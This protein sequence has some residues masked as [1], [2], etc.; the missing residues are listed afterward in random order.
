[1]AWRARG[2]LARALTPLAVLFGALAAARRAAYALGWRV[3]QT[4]AVPVIVVGNL[5]VGGA[6]KTPTVIAVVAALRR[7]GHVPGI[8]S[9][10]YGRRDQAVMAVR[11]DANPADCGD[12]P[13]LLARRT[14]SPVVVGADRV[15][16][17][18]ELLRRHPDV[19]V[20]VS[21]DGLQHLALARQVQVLVFDERG[22]GNGW[23]L[24]AGPLREPLP[25]TLPPRSLVVY[26]ATR[27]TTALPGTVAQRTLDGVVLL[28]DW[29]AGLAPSP[30][31]LQA[32]R[33][34][35]VLAVAGVAQPQRFFDML[36]RHG[37]QI[38]PIPL[39]D[40][41]D[42]V[43][44]PWPAGAADV[45]VT[46]KDAVKLDA[47]RTGAT[48]VWVAPLDFTLGAAFEAALLD[49]L[50]LPGSRHGNTTA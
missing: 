34:R 29:W 13:L 43:T 26:N 4:L 37:L 3:P 15:A 17:V 45:V 46:E 12:E 6:G 42:Y 25:A 33:D 2:A 19:D 20:I 22:A 5:V 9:R 7:R 14:G 1:M 40:H 18:R 32:L 21:D 44:L 47:L 8:V 10:G 11:P 30:A 24:P 28:R 41:Y 36:I 27:A 31:A 39:A 49:L 35:T 16:A 38:E 23:L 50:P 48:R